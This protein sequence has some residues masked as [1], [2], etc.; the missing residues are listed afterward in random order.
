MELQ[1]NNNYRIIAD[2]M[3]V[4]LQERKVYGEKSKDVGKEYWDN[5]GY[6]GSL[7]S[8]LKGFKHHGIRTSECKGYYQIFETLDKIDADILAISKEVDWI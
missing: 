2:S 3:N 5:I 7:E 4:I 1:I 6:Y 8:C